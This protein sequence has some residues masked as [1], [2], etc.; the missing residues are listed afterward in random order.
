MNKIK[1]DI[2]LMK[3]IS[4]FENITHVSPKDC[5]SGDPLIFVVNRGDIAKAIGKNA[6]NIHR[7]E[8][9][10]KKRVKIIEFNDD[11]C[12]FIRN[13]ISPLKV[14]EVSKEEN[15]ITI[16]DPDM[17]TKGMIIGRDSTNLN[18]TKEIVSRYFEFEEIVVR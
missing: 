14:A 4:M 17:K 16:K 11:I 2:D 6:S 18:K 15:K 7:I 13:V 3:F 9:L 12:M 1:Y 8:G 10:L 5:I